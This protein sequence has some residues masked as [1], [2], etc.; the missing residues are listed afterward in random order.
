MGWSVSFHKHLEIQ[1]NPKSKGLFNERKL[2][3][4]RKSNFGKILG[5]L[6]YVAPNMFGV[7]SHVGNLEYPGVGM[8]M[9]FG[10]PY[11]QLRKSFGSN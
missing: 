7:C 5:A 8:A 9:E 2:V 3:R 11:C 1:S 10:S 6:L 4:E